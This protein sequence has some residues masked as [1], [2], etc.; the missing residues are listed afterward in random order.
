[1]ALSLPSGLTPPEV[2]FL[3]EMEIVTVVPRQRLESLELLAVCICAGIYT[4]S[5]LLHSL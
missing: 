5:I 4:L 3:C 1:M 2:Q